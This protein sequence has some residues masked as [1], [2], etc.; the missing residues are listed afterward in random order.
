MIP[1]TSKT[2]PAPGAKAPEAGSEN[3][4]YHSPE[5]AISLGEW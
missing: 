4:T 3:L 1:E 5:K 2:N